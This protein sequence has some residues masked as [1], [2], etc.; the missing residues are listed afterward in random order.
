MK[1]I[2]LTALIFSSISYSK[3]KNKLPMSEVVKAMNLEAGAGKVKCKEKPKEQCICFDGIKWETAKV[4]DRYIE[5]KEKPIREKSETEPC[6]GE[7]DCQAILK[8]K[9]C[10]NFKSEK[11]YNA[12]F[13]EVWC[14]EI[15]G[16]EQKIEGK[17]L[18]ESDTKRLAY[19]QE[20]DSKEATKLAKEQR[21]EELKAEAKKEKDLTKEEIKEILL[22][23][24]ERL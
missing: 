10:E 5:N 16:Y 3:C 13:T 6:E 20:L 17:K 12:E 21:K 9:Q 2:I 7:K 1:Y 24:L 4:V 23:V 22:M 8:G 19:E 14:S 18:I 11:F 15:T